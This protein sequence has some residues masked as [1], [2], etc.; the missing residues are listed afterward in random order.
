M[1][2]VGTVDDAS[3]HPDSSGKNVTAYKIAISILFGLLGFVLNFHTIN[4]PFP[5]YIAVVLIGRKIKITTLCDPLCSLWFNLPYHNR[6]IRKWKSTCTREL[7][8]SLFPRQKTEDRNPE[9]D[10]Q[11]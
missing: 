5:P 11:I 4:L 9:T 7:Q 8:E 6:I 3:G 1:G 2:Q 10:Q